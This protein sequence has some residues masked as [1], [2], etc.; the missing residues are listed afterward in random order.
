MGT[1]GNVKSSASEHQVELC[2]ITDIAVSTY[3]CDAGCCCG[4]KKLNDPL[5]S[6][7]SPQDFD[8]I[9]AIGEP[10]GGYVCPGHFCGQPCCPSPYASNGGGHPLQQMKAEFPGLIFTFRAIFVGCDKQMHWEHVVTITPLAR[11]A[12]VGGI[13][14]LCEYTNTTLCWADLSG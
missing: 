7:L 6:W 4:L 12:Q 14:M 13:I 2:W 1:C 5:P 3:D 8:R 10:Y 9:C 11:G